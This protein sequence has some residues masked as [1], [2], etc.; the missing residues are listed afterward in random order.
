MWKSQEQ[1][2]WA[3]DSN[4]GGP[5]WGLRLCTSNKLPGHADITGPGTMP[6]VTRIKTLLFSGQ[7]GHTHLLLCVYSCIQTTNCRIEYLPHDS[8][9]LQGWKY[10]SSGP[11]GEKVCWPLIQE[12]PRTLG[13]QTQSAPLSCSQAVQPHEL[14][15]GGEEFAEKSMV[16]FVLMSWLLGFFSTV[17]P[18]QW[19]LP[20][21]ISLKVTLFLS[22]SSLCCKCSQE[23]F[24]YSVCFRQFDSGNIYHT[25]PVDSCSFAPFSFTHG[26]GNG[27]PLQCSWLKNPTGEPGGLPS[28]GSHRVGHDWSDLAAAAFTHCC[29]L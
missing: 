28:M 8:D 10:L 22:S 23:P 29:L 18:C 16:H 3:A 11:F 4:S 24:A 2:L 14:P 12:T 13:G 27:N 9:G 19:P 20:S 26:E 1:S 15:H 21:W 17:D 7:L 25:R 5:Q 6:G